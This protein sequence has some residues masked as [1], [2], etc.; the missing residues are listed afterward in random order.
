MYAASYVPIRMGAV[1]PR[2]SLE[3]LSQCQ[4]GPCSSPGVCGLP[5]MP[6]DLLE[7]VQHSGVRIG[8]RP[9]AS[10]QLPDRIL[11]LGSGTRHGDGGRA[12]TLVL[13]TSKG[14]LETH[15]S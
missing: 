4:T 6:N 10:L 14:Y 15:N 1:I 5:F 11:A 13:T 3:K 2:Y 7:A 12:H 8:A 9:F